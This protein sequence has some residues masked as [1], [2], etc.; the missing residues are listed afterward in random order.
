M[1]SYSEEIFAIVFQNLWSSWKTQTRSARQLA[2]KSWKIELK[3][4]PFVHRVPGTESTT[5]I[6]ANDQN[7]PE[8]KFG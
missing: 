1:R 6:L 3:T 2:G 7:D 8:V 4:W 5:T